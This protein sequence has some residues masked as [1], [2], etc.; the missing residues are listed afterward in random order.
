MNVNK[1]D[2]AQIQEI[3]RRL[4]NAQSEHAA[5]VRLASQRKIRARIKMMFAVILVCLTV[6]IITKGLASVLTTF[7]SQPAK[8]EELNRGQ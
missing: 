4:Q 6:F 8:F 5:K 1:D 7:D 3:R 2:N